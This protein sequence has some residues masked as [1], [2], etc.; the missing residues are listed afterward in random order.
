MSA[1]RVR[2]LLEELEQ[3]HEIIPVDLFNKG[4]ETEAYKKYIPW[5]AYR[6]SILTITS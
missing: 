3:D 4:G 6:R 5:V 1:M 2:W